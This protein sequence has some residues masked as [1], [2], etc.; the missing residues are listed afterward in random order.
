LLKA[1]DAKREKE[2]RE[3]GLT[4]VKGGRGEKKDKETQTPHQSDQH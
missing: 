1:K 4:Q 3:G 2:V